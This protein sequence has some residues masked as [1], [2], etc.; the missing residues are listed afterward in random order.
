MNLN[1]LL[2]DGQETAYHLIGYVMVVRLIVPMVQMKQIVVVKHVL[3][4]D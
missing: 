3:I 2:V 1:V 4:K